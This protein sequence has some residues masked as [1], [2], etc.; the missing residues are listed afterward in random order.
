MGCLLSGPSGGKANA[1]AEPHRVA[2]YYAPETDDPLWQ[3][4]CA[5]LGRDPERNA[6]MA[7]PDIAGLPAD[8]A[9]PRRYGLH[10]TLKAPFTP[11]LGFEALLHAA[12]AFAARQQPF[13]LPRLAVTRLHGFLALCPAE[14][15]PELN[16]FAATCVMELDKHRL[17]ED[18]ATQ[19]KRAAGRTARQARHVAR[20]GYPLVLEDFRFHMTLTGNTEDNPYADAASAYFAPA[21]ALPRKVSSLAL[22]VEDEKHAPFRLLRRLPFAP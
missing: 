20:W 6:V 4:G 7:Q 1:L 11:R 22:F 16:K 10:A 18:P 17:P 21:L 13:L 15:S 9:A 14:P 2:L 3:A 12:A 19:A 8:T 5:W